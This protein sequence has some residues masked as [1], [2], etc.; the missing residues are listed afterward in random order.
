VNNATDVARESADILLL[1]SDIGVVING[2]RYGR[3]VFANINKYIR[4]TFVSNWGNFFALSALYLLSVAA[5]PILPV[6]I[7]LASLLTDLPCI[8][9]AT[10]NIDTKELLSPS[11]FIIHSI[12]FIS[13]F[14]GSVTAVFEIMYF[15]IIKNHTASIA[16]T[17]MYLFLTFTALIV[18]FSIRNKEHFWLAPKLSSA[19][20]LAFAF[21]T[22]LAL[23]LAYIPAT[24]KLLSF[25]ALSLGLLT[26]TVLMTIIYFVV[27]DMI[28]VWFY[29]ANFG[30]S[31]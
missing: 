11:R 19:M 22:I 23:A 4:F 1:R 14:L 15:A 8:T 2:I 18:I 9:I 16:E 29:E 21:I 10:D 24:Q 7:L 31:H 17:G 27:M 25:S 3:E 30:N 28:K 12:M 20:K 13:M 5:L 6:Q 26:V